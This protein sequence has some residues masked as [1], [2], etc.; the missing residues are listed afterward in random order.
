MKAFGPIQWPVYHKVMPF[1]AEAQCLK[2]STQLLPAA[3]EPLPHVSLGEPGFFIT[4]TRA[5]TRIVYKM[6][7]VL[8]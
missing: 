3:S 1:D 4:K 8:N 2:I 5:H 6:R 7:L